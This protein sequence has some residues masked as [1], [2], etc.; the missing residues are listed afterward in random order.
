M[1][2]PLFAQTS[3]QQGSVLQDNFSSNLSIV[4]NGDENT[5]RQVLCCNISA[6]LRFQTSTLRQSLA[7]RE[8]LL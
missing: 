8:E 4:A 1:F 2:V 5:A 7:L 3:N 6:I